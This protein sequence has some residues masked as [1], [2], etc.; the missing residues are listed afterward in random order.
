M[1][2]PRV[3][4][5]QF[6][7]N[8]SPLEWAQVLYYAWKYNKDK[9]EIIRSMVT[10]Y[11][12][13]DKRFDPEEFVKFVRKDMKDFLTEEEDDVMREEIRQQAEEYAESRKKADAPTQTMTG[14]RG[15]KRS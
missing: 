14:S 7:V 13:A 2:R 9:R 15:S 1:S 12:T 11:V 10:R 4:V 8:F 6:Y 5:K 3:F